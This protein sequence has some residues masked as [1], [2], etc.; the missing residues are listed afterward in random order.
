M[1]VSAAGCAR[2]TCSILCQAAVTSHRT[3]R[4]R[5]RAW[6]G[7]ANDRVVRPELAERLRAG[8]HASFAALSGRVPGEACYRFRYRSCRPEPHFVS[9]RGQSCTAFVAFQCGLLRPRTALLGQMGN[10]V[11]SR[12]SVQPRPSAPA[13]ESDRVP[14]LLSSLDAKLEATHRTLLDPGHHLRPAADQPGETCQE[15]QA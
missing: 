5:L 10:F 15:H 11:N 12:S 6:L 7:I 2:A 13:A 4:V 1:A 8:R 3:Y 9:S 14:G